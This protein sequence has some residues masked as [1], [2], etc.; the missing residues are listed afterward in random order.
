VIALI[1][2]AAVTV[3]ATLVLAA[4]S[5]APTTTAAP[6]RGAHC[7]GG[8]L[9]GCYTEDQMPAFLEQAV[10]FV[11]GFSDDRYQRMPR[12]AGYQLIPAG[13]TAQSPCG[14]FVGWAQEKGYLEDGDARDIAGLVRAIASSEDDPGRDHGTLAEREA[15]LSTGI[16]DGL[17]GCSAFSPQTPVHEGS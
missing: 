2:L 8:S 7:P 10:T 13:R 16:R 15:A 14:A 9:E 5:G 17:P 12:P 4:A 11:Q 1:V 3:L 6:T